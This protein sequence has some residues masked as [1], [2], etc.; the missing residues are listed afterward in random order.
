VLVK[1]EY[2]KI[3]DGNSHFN[4]SRREFEPCPRGFGLLSLL[5][6]PFRRSRYRKKIQRFFS[7]RYLI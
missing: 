2:S 5:M 6:V 1:N 4:G 3:K 7:V